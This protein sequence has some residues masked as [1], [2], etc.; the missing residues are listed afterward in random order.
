METRETIVEKQA[1]SVLERFTEPDGNIIETSP[2]P[3]DA[4][5][6]EALLRDLF[7]NDWQE[8]AFGPI[9]QGAAWEIEA[10]CAPTYIG[11]LDG[12]ITIAF[13]SPH[14]KLDNTPDGWAIKRLQR[15]TVRLSE[16]FQARGWHFDQMR[17]LMTTP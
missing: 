15:R 13:G 7:A 6:L 1:S 4:A 8:I 5:S 10:P 9:I 17:L 12:Y 11:V 14:F 16:S 3:T 2:L